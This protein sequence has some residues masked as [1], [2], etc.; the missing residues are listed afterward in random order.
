MSTAITALD[1][2]KQNLSR[3]QTD[4]KMVL[5]PNI[6]PERF[7]CVAVTAVQNNPEL[8]NCNRASL[9]NAC[10]KAA[11]DGLLPDG[12]EAV[13]TPFKG[14]V[15]YIPMI[16]GVLKKVHNSGVLATVD[17]QVVYANDEYESW[18]DEKGQHFRHKKAIQNRGEPVLTYAY[19]LTK[20]GALYFEEVSEEQMEKIEAMAKTDTIWKGAFR[21]EMKRKSA[22]HRL[23][24]R[25]PMETD[26]KNVI[27][28]DEELY[29]LPAGPVAPAQPTSSRLDNIID[30]QVVPPA[31]EPVPETPQPMPE[32]AGV[33]EGTI[34]EC[35]FKAGETKGKKWTKYGIKIADIWYGTFDMKIYEACLEFKSNNVLCHVEYTENQYGREMTAIRSKTAEEM[36]IP[37]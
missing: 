4:F 13:L 21:D 31:P 3:M 28:R 27:T 19:A 34:S 9:Y 5:P 12:R 2:V 14:I 25:L 22:L 7:M 15:Q 35:K 29:E 23:S 18:L 1:E 36:G 32:P 8:L 37:I 24:K 11:Q 17:A 33:T 6:S 16:Q 26:I 20:D 10:I 30:T